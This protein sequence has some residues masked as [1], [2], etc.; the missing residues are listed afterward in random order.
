MFFAFTILAS[1]TLVHAAAP[2]EEITE[3]HRAQSHSY[4]DDYKFSPEDGW[5]TL[6]AS[7]EPYKHPNDTLASSL[8]AAPENRDAKDHDTRGLVS[9]GLEKISTSLK[10]IFKGL[11]GEGEPEDVVVTWCVPSSQRISAY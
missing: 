3:L 6:T 7:D 1:L 5:T 11:H 2:P 4:S 9:R 8:A 10:S